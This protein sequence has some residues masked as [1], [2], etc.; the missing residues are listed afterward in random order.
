M[1]KLILLDSLL[2]EEKLVSMSSM[3]A[4]KYQRYGYVHMEPFLPGEKRRA[5]KEMERNMKGYR[6]LRKEVEDARKN[7]KEA[8][9]LKYKKEKTIK[10]SFYKSPV[11]TRTT[12]LSGGAFQ[13]DCS[14]RNSFFSDVNMI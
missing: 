7:M 8:E 13:T 11:G 1:G 14:G 3:L 12:K 5:E 4:T 9:M 2:Q 10:T 6:E